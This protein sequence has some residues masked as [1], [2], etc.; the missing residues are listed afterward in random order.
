[1]RRPTRFPLSGK[2]QICARP[3]AFGVRTI[4]VAT[5]VAPL[6]P[7]LA[8]AQS[9]SPAQDISNQHDSSPKAIVVT[10]TR[11][12]VQNLIDRKAYNVSKD[13]QAGS[14]FRDAP[15]YERAWTCPTLVIHR[16]GARP[17]F[18]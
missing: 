14:G 3:I 15:A 16:S 6:L 7:S 9:A 17:A 1:M 18:G 4:L 10:G 2:R 13:L 12:D 5:A 11:P 8:V